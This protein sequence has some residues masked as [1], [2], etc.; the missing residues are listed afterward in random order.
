MKLLHDK[1]V[2][3]GLQELI[4]KCT[5]KDKTPAKQCTVIKFGKH[6]KRTG[7]EM[8]LTVQIGEYKMD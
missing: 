1:K 4:N 8:R 3:E 7:R 6:K 5:N 2:V